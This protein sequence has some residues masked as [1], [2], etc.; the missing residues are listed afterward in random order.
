MVSLATAQKEGLCGRALPTA[1]PTFD[2][3]LAR[4][5]NTFINLTKEERGVLA[6]IQSKPL[7]VKRCCELTDEGQPCHKAYVLHTG[8]GCSYKIM[9]GGGRQ[10]S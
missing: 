3:A 7:R 8:W 4:K 1:D 9:F 10:I 5:L 2:S 6:D